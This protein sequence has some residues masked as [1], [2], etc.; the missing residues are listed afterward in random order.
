M[1][2]VPGT[3]P[4]GGQKHPKQDDEVSSL[5]ALISQWSIIL[6]STYHV[7]KFTFYMSLWIW[8]ENDVLEIILL[9]CA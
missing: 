4:S 1:I 5:M 3:V 8:L 9:S 6:I 2:K 7:Y